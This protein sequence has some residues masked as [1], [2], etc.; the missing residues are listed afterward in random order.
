VI[1]RRCCEIACLILIAAVVSFAGSPS[2]RRV[3]L[4]DTLADP[5]RV[6][7]DAIGLG[8]RP[9]LVVYERYE[10]AD[11]AAE[12]TGNIDVESLVR[13][14]ARKTGGV[15]PEWGLLDFEDPFME[16]MELG[17]GDPKWAIATGQMRD[18]IRAV[19]R[20]FP[21][22]KWSFYQVP[23]VRY[24]IAGKSWADASLEQ[25]QTA[26]SRF[27]DQS[28]PIIAECDWICPSI[29]SFYDPATR[30]P[31]DAER[32]RK[33]SRAWSLEQ[34]RIACGVANG[35]P[36]VP[37]I[38]PIWQPNGDAPIGAPVP[39]QLL[40]EDVIEPAIRGGAAG[41]VIWTAFDYFIGCAVSGKEPD[42][43]GFDRAAVAKYYFNGRSPEDWSD[44]IVVSTVRMKAGDVVLSAIK[45][46]RDLETR[47]ELPNNADSDSE[48]SK[49]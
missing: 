45:A 2:A 23:Y 28:A 3:I 31:S 5:G 12:R 30:H 16:W 18:A 49:P 40:K 38:S 8:A 22:T 42:P 36:V 32:V 35:R 48:S 7:E 26:A 44:P 13:H 15:P 14:I 20:A 19:K 37:I 24:W 17:P 29:Y 43:R 46:I 6:G 21:G 9:L 25:R 1:N 11:P 47:R 27:L 4:F 33:A 10:G 41:F 34:V 39:I